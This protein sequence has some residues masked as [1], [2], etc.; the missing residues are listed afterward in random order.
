[1]F[2]KQAEGRRGRR[3]RWPAAVAVAGVLS[4]LAACAPGSDDDDGDAEAKNPSDIST[5]VSK[6]GDVTLTVW[7]QEVRGGQDA[8]IKKLNAEFEAKYDNVTIKRVSRSFDD[9]KTTLG[10]ALSGNDPPDIVQA[11][12]GYG[13]MG[14]FVKSGYLLPLDNYAEVYKWGDRYPQ[15]LLDLNSFSEDGKNFGS[16]NLYGLSQTGEIIGIYYNKQK[17][18]ALGIDEPT[19]W[20][21]FLDALEKAKSG[22]EQPIQLGNQEGWPAIHLFGLVQGQTAGKQDVRDLVFS[23]EGASWEDDGTVEAAQVLTD[24]MDKGYLPKGIN[25]QGYDPAWADFTKGKG[26]FLIA[27][28]WL[29]PDMEKA[30]GSNLGFMLPP[31]A[32]ADADPVTTGGQGLPWSVTAKS[33]NPDVAAAYIDF[34][35]TR[36]AADVM[37]QEGILPVVQP[38]SATVPGG[39]AQENM[40]QSWTEVRD[41]DGLVPYLDYTTPTFYDT[42]T[43][44][45][46]ELLGGQSSPEDFTK[47]L[48]KDYSEFLDS[49]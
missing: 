22:G 49:K 18:S 20:Q 10:N 15:T 12:Q 9:L 19:T 23:Q 39:T 36:K 27:G 5:D 33:K 21:D 38:D 11:N 8:E 7:D 43:A 13:D 1:M 41:V 26:V 45:L 31:G 29:V 37:T 6:A 44:R 35:T 3:A 4:L 16:G 42:I 47:A 48:E 34:I 14:T 2:G 28:T 32:E 46:Q 17:M 40:V 30:M 24:W 25:G